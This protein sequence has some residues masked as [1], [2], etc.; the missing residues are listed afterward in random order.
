M[1]RFLGI[2]VGLIASLGGVPAPVLAAG[3]PLVISTTVNYTNN[4]LTISG[5]NFGSSPTVTLDSMSFPTQSVS[6]GQI[7]ADFPAGSPPSSFRPGTYF[8]T[9][10]S[11]HQ[12]PAIFT[13][14]IG[15]NGPQGPAGVQGLAGAQGATGAT[16][17]AGP[18]GPAGAN[19]A[20]GPPGAPGQPGTNG[21]NGTNGAQGLQGAQGPQGPQGLQGP[22]GAPGAS[23]SGGGLPTGCGTTNWSGASVNVAV[24]PAVFYTPSGQTGAWTCKSQLPRYVANGDGTL[25]DNLS[26]LM[27]EMATGVVV[28]LPNVP[29][30]SSD[31]KDVNASY[32]WSSAGSGADGTLFTIFI[33]GLNGGVYYSPSFG[34]TVGLAGT[35][36][37]FANHCDWRMPTLAELQTIL[38][39]TAPA[40]CSFVAACIDPAFGP[41]QAN[42]YWSSS[43]LVLNGK[44]Y[45]AWNIFF[46][47]GDISYQQWTGYGYARAVRSVR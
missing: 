38:D 35:G 17:P 32:S 45:S 22:A 13:V 6:S 40:G 46:G 26:G 7:V 44:P 30:P 1:N 36:P 3:L 43:S 24:D 31:V 29:P 28:P 9:M 23:G 8:L 41:T 12:F 42:Y 21:M 11:P 4:T 18:V 14:D 47:N 33:A 10:Q 37:C 16:G 25:T 5:Q 34:G 2:L 19:G 15:A 27:W 20:V 39:I